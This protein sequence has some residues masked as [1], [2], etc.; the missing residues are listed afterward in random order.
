MFHTIFDD[1]DEDNASLDLLLTGVSRHQLDANGPKLK[2]PWMDIA[3]RYND[4]GNE[5]KKLVSR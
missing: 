4:P 2:N 5:F 3:E 1:T